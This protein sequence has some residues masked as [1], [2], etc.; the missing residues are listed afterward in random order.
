MAET[1]STAKN[2]SV[3]GL[4]DAGILVSRAGKVRLLRPQE[5]AE[6]WD[7]ERDSRLSAWE[8]VHQLAGCGKTLLST[9]CRKLSDDERRPITCSERI[10]RIGLSHA[11]CCR[12]S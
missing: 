8:T 3:S 11:E 9:Q 4:V 12:D 5:L 7:P 10:I 2:T 1:L 6:D